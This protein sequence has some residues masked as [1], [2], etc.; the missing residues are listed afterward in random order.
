[1]SDFLMIGSKD[2]AVRVLLH[3]D[4]SSFKD[5]SRYKRTITN[6]GSVAVDGTNK[7]FG[8]GSASMGTNKVLS[9]AHAADVDLLDQDF[10]IDFRVRSTSSTAGSFL[11]KDAT[12]PAGVLTGPV[13]ITQGFN[14][15]QLFIDISTNSSLPAEFR[16]ATANEALTVNTWHHAAVTRSGGTIYGF[17]DGVLI[18]TAAIGTDPLESNAYPWRIGAAGVTAAS[19]LSYMQGQIDEFRMMIGK[20][21][22]TANFTPPAKPYHP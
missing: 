15:R 8:A 3:M 4:E 19:G 16:I 12:N 9:F 20:C 5:V 14:T 21:A 17:L 13:L 22:W 6:T 10:T 1:M 2:P 18:D 11:S 7:V